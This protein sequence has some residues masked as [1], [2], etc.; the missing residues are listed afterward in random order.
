MNSSGGVM[1]KNKWSDTRQSYNKVDSH[2]AATERVKKVR[3]RH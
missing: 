1:N 2:T 3:K